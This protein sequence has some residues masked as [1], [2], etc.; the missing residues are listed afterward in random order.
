MT[1]IALVSDSSSLASDWDMNALLKAC[2]SIGLNATVAFWND[3]YE[4]WDRFDAAVLRSP[5]SYIEQPDAFHAWMA[6]VE[7]R[8]QL[9]NPRRVS[10][11]SLHKAYLAELA[12]YGVPTV[13]VRIITDRNQV[14]HALSTI[15]SQ[16]IVV[17]PAVG[18][19][20]KDVRR[21]AKGQPALIEH[22]ANLLSRQTDVVVQPYMES[23]VDCPETNLTFFNGMFSHA[24]RKR[25]LIG[26]DG[27][28]LEPTQDARSMWI[29]DDSE[30][31]VAS[32][33][34][35][36]VATHFDLASPLLYARV[37]LL[38]NSQGQ[39]IV[40]EL[41]LCE[42][43]LNLQFDRRAPLTFATAIQQRVLV[44]ARP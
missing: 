31:A 30:I 15:A 1:N 7:T 11:W 10:S 33:V 35:E 14:E 9:L 21:F 44:S 27:I 26:S 4:T 28:A 22:V 29:P 43:S 18:A 16:N 38:H 17:K 41:E 12:D 20:S 24:I 2:H 13:P 40:H 3:P 8:T 37:D 36:T 5:W 39:P 23:I 6:F 19:N 42:P 25:P 32:A 34:V